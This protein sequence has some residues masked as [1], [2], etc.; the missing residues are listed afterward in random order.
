MFYHNKF[1]SVKFVFSVIKSTE[2]G[3]IVSVCFSSENVHA[4]KWIHVSC[5]INTAHAIKQIYISCKNENNMIVSVS[6]QKKIF[7]NHV[8]CMLWTRNKAKYVSND[9]TL[10]KTLPNNVIL[11]FFNISAHEIL[12]FSK[13][14]KNMNVLTI[15]I[16]L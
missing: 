13:I 8:P 5:M 16:W 12:Y 15:F 3:P 9:W 11:K 14:E 6:H 10:E 1:S 4:E 2:K 7:L